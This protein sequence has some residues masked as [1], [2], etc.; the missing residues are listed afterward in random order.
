MLNESRNFLVVL[1]FNDK[2]KKKEA[3]MEILDQINLSHK[4]IDIPFTGKDIEAFCYPV[5]SNHSNWRFCGKDTKSARFEHY[6]YAYL[7]DR[8]FLF[9][10]QYQTKVIAIDVDD[11]PR[12][13]LHDCYEPGLDPVT[14]ENIPL[15]NITVCTGNGHYQAFWRLKKAIP[16]KK[17]QKCQEYFTDVRSKLNI[18]LNGDFAFNKR[19][20]A[21]NPFNPSYR[22]RKWHDHDFELGD[23]NLN[24]QLF[25][26]ATVSTMDNLYEPGNR[27]R[28]T[29][30]KALNFFKKNPLIKFDDLF[31]LIKTWQNLHEAENLSRAENAGII[32][33]VLRNGDKYRLRAD[34]NYGA[35]NLPEVQ[36]EELTRNGRYRKIK[37]R[38]R[39][40]AYYTHDQRREKSK[41]KVIDYY[42][43]NK[44]ASIRQAAK[45]L[46]MH[47][48]TIRKYKPEQVA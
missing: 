20:G 12:C 6:N 48:C 32:K 45:D 29:F 26:L 16:Q 1:F 21:R 18:A 40:G 36:W 41:S 47:R 37:Q 9:Y 34:R 25:K 5:D 30:I 8:R 19:G 17:A 14:F 3:K 46:N 42:R 13:D 28:S 27:N 24:I 7:L 38:Q 33:S 31:E 39:L 4:I 10:N 43:S 23:L 15:P 2:I 35:M 11:C 22:V 44:T